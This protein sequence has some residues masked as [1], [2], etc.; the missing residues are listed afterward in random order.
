MQLPE[1]TAEVIL[2]VLKDELRE[3]ES[4][5]EWGQESPEDAKRLRAIQDAVRVLENQLIPF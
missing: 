2:G 4:W 3:H 5:K 1:H